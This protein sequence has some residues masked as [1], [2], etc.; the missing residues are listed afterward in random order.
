MTWYYH[1]LLDKVAWFTTCTGKDQLTRCK[2]HYF[3]YRGMENLVT[4]F[5]AIL[6]IGKPVRNY[7]D[8]M[9]I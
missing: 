2:H 3:K 7:S 4:V 6:T 5:D 1:S 8:G 9:R